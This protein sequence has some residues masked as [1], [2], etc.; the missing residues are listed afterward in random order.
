MALNQ[1]CGCFAMLTSTATIFSES[2][3]TLSPNISS[4]IVG[5]IQIIGSMFPTLLVDRL[6]RKMMMGLSAYGTCIGLSVLGV[7]TLMKSDGVDLKSYSWIPLVAFSFVIFI[8][9]WG[10]LTLPFMIVSEISHPKV[11]QP[12]M[13]Y[14]RKTLMTHKS[15]CFANLQIRGFVT[16][17][18]MSFLWIFAFIA[19]KVSVIRKHFASL[20]RMLFQYS[21]MLIDS[22]GMHGTMFLFSLNSLVGALFITIFLPETRGKSFDEIVNLLER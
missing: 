1:F 21:P 4:I 11:I 15:L 5:G 2:G 17:L 3:S 14:D 19:I 20:I 9:N 13:I 18:C 22:L 8:A 7:Y 12:L 6:G 10:L 16:I